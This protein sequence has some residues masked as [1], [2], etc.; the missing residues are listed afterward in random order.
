MLDIWLSG[1]ITQLTSLP[2]CVRIERWIHREYS[3]LRDEQRLYLAE[4]VKRTLQ[5]VSK[6]VDRATP[7]TI[8]RI[9]NSITYAYLRR[10]EPVT[11]KDLRK[12]F[13][14]WPP[15]ITTG[16]R[17][18]EALGEEDAGYAGDIR[19]TKEW[20]T[21]LKVDDW[22]A[23]IGFENMPESYFNDVSALS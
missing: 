14:G 13:S 20:A 2:A 1:I 23:W 7:K 4:D 12:H 19:V 3:P 5:G 17:L 18:Y 15:I 16:I 9:S 6:K 10:I 22:F 21:I 8:F 11:G